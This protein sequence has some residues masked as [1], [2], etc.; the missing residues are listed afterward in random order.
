M[1]GGA[2]P[3]LAFVAVFG[4]ALAVEFGRRRRSPARWRR[5]FFERYSEGELLRVREASQSL[6][7]RHGDD[8]GAARADPVFER[9][10]ARLANALTPLYAQRAARL[11]GLYESAIGLRALARRRESPSAEAVDW[12]LAQLRICPSALEPLLYEFLL[13]TTRPV[14]GSVLALLDEG[15]SADSLAVF[16]GERRA[17]EGPSVETFAGR[18]PYRHAPLIAALVAEHGPTLGADFETAFRMWVSTAPPD[19]QPRAQEESTQAA[20]LAEAVSSFARVW[21]A[22]FDRPTALLVG[23][24]STIVDR[25]ERAFGSPS[26]RSVL[27]VGEPGVGKTR[28]LRAALDRCRPAL[29]FEAGAAET[30]AGCVY[31]GELEARTSWI[32]ETIGGRDAV[33]IF[34]RLD[35]AVYTGQHSRSPRGLLDALLPHV[36]TGAL[37]IAAEVTPAGYARLDGERPGALA[38]FD[39]VHVPSLERRDAVEVAGASLA[40]TALDVTQETLADAFDLAAHVVTGQSSPGNVIGLLAE[41]ADDVLERGRSTLELG[42]V[43]GR[44]AATYALPLEMLDRSTPLDLER[45][46]AFFA[47]RILNQPEAVGAVVDRIALIKAGL[48]DPGTPLGVLFLVGPTGTGKTELART[49]AEFVFGSVDRLI[50]L[51]MSEYQT[52]EAFERLLAPTAASDR[53]ASLASAIRRDPFAVVLLDE[54]EKAAPAVFDLFLQIFDDGRITDHAGDVV[55]FRRVLFV[56]TSNVGAAVASR[57][58]PGFGHANGPGFDR[59]AV[60]REV[61]RAFRPEFVNRLDSIV[62]FRPFERA[63]M[64]ALLEKELGSALERRGISTRPWAVELDES[65]RKFLIEHG[66]SAQ[67]GARPLKRAIERHLL[68]PL[69]ETI[70]GTGVPEGERFLLVR[71]RGSRLSVEF[72]DPDAEPARCAPAPQ[73]RGRDVRSIA[74]G[75]TAT[76]EDVAVLAEEAARVV[77]ALDTVDV[78]GRKDDAL[79]AMTRDGFWDDPDRLETLALVEYLDR[80]E[81]AAENTQRLARRLTRHA[82][83]M[84]SADVRRLVGQ[85]AV[86]LHVLDSALTG[87]QAGSPHDVVLGLKP[88]GD[89]D[90]RPHDH[91]E[92]LTTMY[93]RWAERR[94]MRLRGLAENG[95]ERL[96]AASGLGCAVILLPEAGLHVLGPQPG[97]GSRGDAKHRR[98]PIQV[99]VA[100]FRPGPDQ[101]EATLIE[102]AR[103]AL[104]DTDCSTA[105][106]RRY[107]TGSAPLVKDHA[108]GY[109]TGRLSDVLA[110]DFDLF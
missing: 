98:V 67:F 25:L 7:A 17:T 68:V 60:V 11:D 44:L 62:V 33:W 9:A 91:V 54:F 32:V 101:E 72:V 53:G 87:V 20:E 78:R 21:P 8:L 84:D 90:D 57:R 23:N 55:D 16:I 13:R 36:D 59:E 47:V 6:T 28:L 69:A 18:V 39:V 50:R 5:R 27:L 19:M 74:L 14:I 65:A 64:D 75:P 46:R 56:L 95:R 89:A 81:A 38:S 61:E 93:L 88:W 70:V 35:D 41:T 107:T 63:Q 92:A 30:Y 77:D 100:P 106:V 3:L 45:V 85:V 82:A 29:V 79:E 83:G 108:R 49:L 73:T 43:L 2:A 80:L 52:P 102:R 97:R 15:L 104:R 94:G 1:N 76:S 71:A 26:R 103:I 86:R 58:R 12:A 31:V 37:T 105:V 110:G 4:V 42:D 40:G 24:R 22:P 109:R 34:P 99:C 48:T 51:D 10:V 66:F 96:F